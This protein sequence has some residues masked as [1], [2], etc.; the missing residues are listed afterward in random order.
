MACQCSRHLQFEDDFVFEYPRSWV[1][2]P[3]TLRKGVYIA[4]FQT[5][6]KLAVEELDVPPNG[7]L[8]TA[9]VAAAVSPGGRQ[10]DDTLVLPAQRLI[11]AATTDV[12]GQEYLYMEFPSETTTRS[13]YN[14]KRKNFVAAAVK[15]DKL[16][17]I[18]ASARSDQYNDDKKQLLQH[19]IQSFRLK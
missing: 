2:R 18:A 11:K 17:M 15:R 8:I 19:C 3:N 6:D 14:I 10:E 12:D 9:A 4:D 13:G 1:A 16:Y 7:D 5:A